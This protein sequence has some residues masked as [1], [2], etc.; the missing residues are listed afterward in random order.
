MEQ[1]KQ[2]HIQKSG[3]RELVM[4]RSFAAPR[5]LV[6]AAHT[7]P[8]LVPQWLNGPPGWSMSVCEIDLQPGGTFRYVWKNTAGTEMGMTGTYVEIAE[9]ERLVHREIFDEDWTGGETLVTTTFEER[10]DV[11]FMTITVEYSSGNARDG[12]MQT[13]MADGMEAGYAQLDD[14][15]IAKRQ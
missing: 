13:G 12:A 11:T 3:E 10:D 1:I 2:L 7:D 4:T 5:Q 8:E 9:P 6:F 14:W 15:L